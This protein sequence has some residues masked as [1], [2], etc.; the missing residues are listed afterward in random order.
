MLNGGSYDVLCMGM[1]L[2]GNGFQ[3]TVRPVFI[4]QVS[5]CGR[6]HVDVVGN[7]RGC[8][9]TCGI[10]PHYTFPFRDS[11]VC[12]GWC[13]INLACDAVDWLTATATSG[14]SPSQYD[15]VTIVAIIQIIVLR[16]LTFWLDILRCSRSSLR[17]LTVRLRCW[18]EPWRI[19]CEPVSATVAG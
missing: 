13:Y 7:D 17:C 19:E 5:L 10:S 6:H 11:V 3:H 12:R 4:P 16:R 9:L 1:S 8:H 14:V 18:S 15:D 2:K